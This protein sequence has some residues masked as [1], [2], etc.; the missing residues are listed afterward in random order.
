MA[1]DGTNQLA[2]EMTLPV[3]S[4]ME[5]PLSS[6]HRLDS[7]PVKMA[8]RVLL[9]LFVYG[10]VVKVTFSTRCWLHQWFLLWYFV[11][12]FQVFVSINLFQL[13]F[14]QF[15]GE[16]TSEVIIRDFKEVA[17]SLEGLYCEQVAQCA[18]RHWGSRS[19]GWSS[20]PFEFHPSTFGWDFKRLGGAILFTSNFER[21]WALMDLI[22]KHVLHLEFVELMV[23]K[24]PWMDLRSPILS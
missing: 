14:P 8:A 24:S 19:C 9:I 10:L 6:F 18:A 13:F 4:V 7:Q 20:V 2:Y 11:R 23:K 12:K 21:A 3:W 17:S 22:S 5:A 15:W 1:F 16:V